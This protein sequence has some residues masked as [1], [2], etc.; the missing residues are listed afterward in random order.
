[1]YQ[2]VLAV[3]KVLMPVDGHSVMGFEDQ[4]PPVSIGAE[5]VLGEGVREVVFETVGERILTVREYPTHSEFQESTA[6][7]TY[8]GKND[9]VRQLDI[10][11]FRDE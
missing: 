6:S 7:G 8:V 3:D 10:D 2:I 4:N 9:A 5:Y 1:L 11:S